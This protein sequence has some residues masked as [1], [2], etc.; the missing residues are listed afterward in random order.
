MPDIEKD[1]DKER[2]DRCFPVTREIMKEMASGLVASDASQV[3]HTDLIMK[4]IALFLSSDLNVTEDT[5]YVPQLILGT[6]AGLNKTAHECTV[7]PIDDARYSVIAGKILSIVSEAEVTLGTV[8][9]EQT[10]KDFTPVKEKLNALFAEE[11][12]TLLELKYILDNIF[13]AFKDYQEKL[14]HQIDDSMKRA[15]QKL[16]KVEFMSDITMKQLNEVLIKK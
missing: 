4:S 13:D 12:L 11:K 5:P 6:L 10:E 9:P 1:L 16:F 7:I 15:E 2:D 14:G 3:K 8:T